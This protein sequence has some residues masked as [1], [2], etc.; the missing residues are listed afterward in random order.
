MQSDGFVAWF[1]NE[2]R[3]P[4]SFCVPYRRKGE[5]RPLYPDLIVFR[6]IKGKLQVDLLDPH[7]PGLPDASEKAVGLARY[8]ERHG[9]FFGRIE[10]AVVGEKNEVKRLDVNKEAIRQK[11]LGVGGADHLEAIFKGQA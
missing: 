9:D 8:A 6:R 2:P 1:R 7:D 5:D 10:L 3:K 11:I 4:W